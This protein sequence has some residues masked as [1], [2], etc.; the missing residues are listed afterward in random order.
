MSQLKRVQ[1]WR[2]NIDRFGHPDIEELTVIQTGT[3]TYFVPSTED[4][5]VNSRFQMITRGVDFFLDEKSALG[6]LL[7][8]LKDAINGHHMAIATL[9]A[10]AGNV[11]WMLEKV[12]ENG[13]QSK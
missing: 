1:G 5:I 12:E 10:E 11:K 6:V 2:V 13:S 8:R 7:D 3:D 4:G 9:S